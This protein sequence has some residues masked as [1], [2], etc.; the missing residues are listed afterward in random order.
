MQSTTTTEQTPF[1]L[2]AL[3][4]WLRRQR[5]AGSIHHEEQQHIWQ[6]F[7]YAEVERILSDP[8]AFSS[9]FSGIMPAQRDF[10]LF[11]R[12][13]F[14]RM[15]P[16]RHRKLRGLVSQAFTPRMIHGLAHR[17]AELTAELLDELGGA[18]RFD[19]VD[20]LAH[21]L[22]VIVIA[23]LLGIP[24]ADRTIFRH[25]ADTLFS[26]NEQTSEVKLD[27][28]TLKA[29]FDAVAPTMREMNGY[30]LA[31]IQDRRA[32][33][34]N[35]LMTELV[36]AEVDGER[37]DDQEIV[38]F[39]G[40]LLI[41]GHITTT[42]LLGNAII[43]LDEHPDAAAELRTD[44]TRLPAA[45]EE[46]L[47]YRPPFPRLARRAATDV[48]LDGHTIGANQVLILWVASANRDGAEF[49]D[50]DRFDI[51]R[52]PNPHLAFGHGIHFC[53]GAPLARLES[54]IALGILL[55]RYR[56]IA[57]GGDEPVEFHN[58][59]TMIS[60]KRLPVVVQAA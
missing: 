6:V 59:W 24:A 15:D 43:T 18:D 55:E 14:V 38:G 28:A 48:D 12:G 35:D 27:E 13:N 40:L 2:E 3:L 36:N 32:R 17:I 60:A 33:P 39:V 19:L 5:E 58:P 20:G 1:I 31:H 46:V 34:A 56:R 16:P 44:P 45:I 52:T 30:L 25:W 53:L 23:E 50:P 47:R 42:A 11:A 37:L 54:K 41:A 51:Y 4:S 8:R 21:P 57:V 9:D 10:D 22:P 26:Q 29:L 7:G 49:P